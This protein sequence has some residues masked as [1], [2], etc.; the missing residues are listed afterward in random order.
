M[1]HILSRLYE[2]VDT[3]DTRLVGT[4]LCIGLD[5][6]LTTIKDA[7]LR[8]YAPRKPL[9]I[10]D[11][12]RVVEDFV[13]RL[14]GRP[15]SLG[16]GARVSSHGTLGPVGTPRIWGRSGGVCESFSYPQ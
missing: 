12:P 9:C 4:A 13:A 6:L 10:S 5:P 8:L 2:H 16:G 7:A 3:V 15:G 14:Q 1:L 11:D